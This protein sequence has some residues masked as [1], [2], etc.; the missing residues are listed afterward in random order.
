VTAITIFLVSGHQPERVLRPAPKAT[1]WAWKTEGTGDD[2][3]TEG[4]APG[5]PAGS[6]GNGCEIGPSMTGACEGA[7]NG[8]GIRPCKTLVSGRGLGKFSRGFDCG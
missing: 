7:D 2:P 5:A 6:E 1:Y 4:G 3:K 8:E